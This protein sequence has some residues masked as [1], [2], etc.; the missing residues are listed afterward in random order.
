MIAIRLGKE[1]KSMN[2]TV[3]WLIG[4]VAM[5]AIEIASLGLTTIW[6]A[7]GA[8]VATIASALGAPIWIQITLFLTVSVLLLI[9]TRP[10]V[11]K[12]F[13]KDR[14]K[15]NVEGMIGK[16]AIVISQID[17]L[18]GIGQVSVGGIEWSA[19]SGKDG[20]PIAVGEVVHVLAVNGVKLIVET[21]KEEN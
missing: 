3:M 21:R 4:L 8:L 17:N 19:R 2:L 9:F 16:Q 13:N 15:T 10:I 18:K 20:T 6:F 7:G 1:I 14:A 11:V 5:V 12:Y